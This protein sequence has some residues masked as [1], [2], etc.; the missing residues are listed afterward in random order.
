MID[1]V[2]MASFLRNGKVWRH[3][4]HLTSWMASAVISVYAALGKI[5]CPD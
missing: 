3:I 4:V 2:T 1:G 5:P